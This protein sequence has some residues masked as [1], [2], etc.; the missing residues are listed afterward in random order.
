MNA[1]VP[2]TSAFVIQVRELNTDRLIATRQISADAGSLLR[3]QMAENLAN[4][5]ADAR[6]CYAV[7]F[8]KPQ[9]ADSDDPGTVITK[10][11]LGI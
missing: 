10:Y 2:E 6:D 7:E 9:G 3:R 4:R 8:R 1:T 5:H 11:E